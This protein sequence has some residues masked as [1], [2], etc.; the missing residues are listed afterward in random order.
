VILGD[1]G[2]GVDDRITFDV[3]GSLKNPDFRVVF[4][5]DADG[6]EVVLGRSSPSGLPANVLH[7]WFDNPQTTFDLG[8][9]LIKAGHQLL[10]ELGRTSLE[11]ALSQGNGPNAHVT[12]N[13][14]G[15]GRSKSAPGG[16]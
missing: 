8:V 9:E 15:Q 1:G 7:L 13:G 3:Y 5:E 16:A 4:H 11:E 10:K 6:V 2:S 12:T 14:G